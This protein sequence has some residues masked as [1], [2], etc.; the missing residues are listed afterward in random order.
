M[1]YGRWPEATRRLDLS[2]GVYPPPARRG[3]ASVYSQEKRTVVK[4]NGCPDLSSLSLPRAAT[5]PFFLTLA[6]C[7]TFYLCFARW[8]LAAAL[9]PSRPP[10][11][12]LDE[13]SQRHGKRA[14]V[15]ATAPAVASPHLRAAASARTHTTLAYTLGL[16]KASL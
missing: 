9:T 1:F 10:L 6:V 8:H 11:L 12:C 7:V 2:T 4:R 3:P 13:Q 5:R 14:E 15:R 16:K